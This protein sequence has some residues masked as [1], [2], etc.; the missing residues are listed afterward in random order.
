[1]DK[2]DTSDQLVSLAAEV[3]ALLLFSS[4]ASRCDD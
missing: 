3:F 1:M 2:G 4:C